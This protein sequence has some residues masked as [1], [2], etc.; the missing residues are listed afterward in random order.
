LVERYSIRNLS[1]GGKD[2]VFAIE[3]IAS[4][5]TK[6]GNFTFVAGLWK[7][8]LPFNLLWLVT[9]D[10]LRKRPDRLQPTWSWASVDG[11]ISCRP[12][13]KS[14]S[15]KVTQSTPLLKIQVQEQRR[16]K[17]NKIAETSWETITILISGQDVYHESRL[18]LRGSVFKFNPHNIHYYPDVDSEEDIEALLCLPILSLESRVYLGFKQR[19]QIRGIILSKEATKPRAYRRVGYFWTKDRNMEQAALGKTKALIQIM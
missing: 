9:E 6:S 1:A 4:F 3:G 15:W 17:P 5:I 14:R 2:K 10:E 19:Y 11:R 12:Q 8:F 16:R 7:E 13:G 18:E